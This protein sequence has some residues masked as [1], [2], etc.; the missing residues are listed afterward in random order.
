LVVVKGGEAAGSGILPVE[1]GAREVIAG[2]LLPGDCEV[3]DDG[4]LDMKKARRSE[5]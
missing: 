2:Q 1:R 3:Y 4:P 5:P